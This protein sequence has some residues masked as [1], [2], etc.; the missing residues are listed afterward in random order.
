VI[1]FEEERWLIEEER[2]L[3]EEERW[4][5]GRR[6]GGSMGGGEVAQSRRRGGSMVAHLTANQ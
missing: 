5:N 4:L 2:W 6:R 3:N 1:I